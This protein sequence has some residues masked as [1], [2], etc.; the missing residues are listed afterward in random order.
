MLLLFRNGAIRFNDRDLGDLF[1]FLGD[2]TTERI[3]LCFQNPLFGRQFIDFFI[4][5]LNAILRLF[6]KDEIVI[7][8]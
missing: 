5:G 2:L 1:L 3:L 8:D 4:Q 7:S 6:G